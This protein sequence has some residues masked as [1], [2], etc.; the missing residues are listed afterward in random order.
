VTSGYAILETPSK[1][2]ELG[3]NPQKG[4][5]V[6]EWSLKINEN[7]PHEATNTNNRR[8]HFQNSR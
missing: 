2:L 1:V 7:E 5:L 8:V 6:E 3:S 4:Q